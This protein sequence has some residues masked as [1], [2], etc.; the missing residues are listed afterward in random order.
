MVMLLISLIVNQV[1]TAVG[2]GIT[3]MKELHSTPFLKMEML[4]PGMISR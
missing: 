3:I 1:V 4:L 2:T